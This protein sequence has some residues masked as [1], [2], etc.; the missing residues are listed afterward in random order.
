[1]AGIAMW[2]HAAARPQEAKTLADTE[3]R[4]VL[5]PAHE[6][7]VRDSTAASTKS[8]DRAMRS[9]SVCAYVPMVTE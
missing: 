3:L 1:M 2:L 7:E 9:R 5:A 6:A 8:R 4:D